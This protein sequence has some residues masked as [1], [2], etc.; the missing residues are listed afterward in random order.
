MLAVH[1]EE[2]DMEG[3]LA[4]WHLIVVALLCLVLFGSK[5]LP[6]SARSLGQSLRIFKAEMRGLGADDAGDPQPLAAGQEAASAPPSSPGPSAA[7]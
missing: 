7:R 3:A 4:P 6:E 2:V 1:A 5:R